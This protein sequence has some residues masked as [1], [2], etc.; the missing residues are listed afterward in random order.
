MQAF[1]LSLVSLLVCST[2]A[3]LNAQA[4]RG[5]EM[6]AIF[7]DHMVLQAGAPTP[8][9]G[10]ANPGSKVS[11]TVAG[12]QHSATSDSRGRWSLN[13]SA[14]KAGGPHEM[15]VSAGSTV[16]I[17][18]ILV[19]EVWL[20]SG[21]SNMA[22]KVNGCDNAKEEIANASFP[23]IRM[24]TVARTPN[25]TAQ[26][27][28]K[29]SWVV[30]SPNTVKAFSATAYFFGRRLHKELS[31]PVGL[32][33]SSVG[34]TPIEAWTSM[35]AQTK[36]PE[37]RA[38]LTDWHKR[39]ED[40]RPITN[41][42]FQQRIQAWEKRVEKAKANGKRK[43]RRP[44]RPSDPTLGSGHPANLYHG[45]IHPLI[46]YRIR[47]ALWYQGERN[48]KSMQSAQLY[49][50]QLP[51]LISDWRTRWGQGDF[52]FLFVQL[53]N[54]KKPQSDPNQASTWAAMRDSMLHSLHVPNTGMATTIDVGMANNIHPKNKQA[55][56][57]RLAQW[58]LATVYDQPIPATGPLFQSAEYRDS[59]AFVSFQASGGVLQIQTG[60]VLQG[61]ALAGKD[62]V[63]QF[64]KAEIQA[65]KVRVWHPAI[66]HPVA[67]RYAWG[68][69]PACNL[70]NTAKLPASPFRSDS[71]GLR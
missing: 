25:K 54:F 13:L 22:M 21:Q 1:Y 27:N 53:P 17:Q 35:P 9:W 31:V 61:F 12:Q 41:A 28:C 23:Q 10:W 63:F 48:A 6:P 32:L 40:W 14:I 47:G 42:Q 56:G 65:G 4:T 24:F 39:G 38:L 59:S 37:L 60:N 29:G 68:D 64:A 30:C 51:L 62:Q 57:S 66:P 67:V 18:D 16:R 33:N 36:T 15:Q 70:G 46:P 34:G 26:R 20:G 58:A 55:V 44:N 43:P 69:N 8:V 5:L 2:T 71:W 49:K 52:P 3:N 11:V 50:T 45:M 7:S 19:G